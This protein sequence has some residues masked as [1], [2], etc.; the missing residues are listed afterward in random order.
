MKKH[1]GSTLAL[2][3]GALSLAA[4]A[5][6]PSN[7]LVAGPI[8]ILG[9]LAYR[10]AK[11]RILGEVTNSLLRKSLEALAVVVIVAAVLLQNDLKNQI[12]TDP[13]PNLII[14]LWAIVAYTT[15]ALK[16]KTQELVSRTTVG[17]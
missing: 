12:I 2:I 5:A 11:K 8:I 16:K 13:V 6:K 7:L 15:V 3:L 17:S 4:G 1:I 9:A 14:P 10:S